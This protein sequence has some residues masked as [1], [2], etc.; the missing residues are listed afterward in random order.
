MPR[1]NGYK[2]VES[3][4]CN[5]LYPFPPSSVLS[6]NINTINT[7]LCSPFNIY[8]HVSI[9]GSKNAF[10]G[11][12]VRSCISRA[13]QTY[14]QDIWASTS[15]EAPEKTLKLICFTGKCLLRGPAPVHHT[16]DITSVQ[17]SS[18]PK[19][20]ANC[21]LIFS[22]KTSNFSGISWLCQ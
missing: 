21:S 17:H 1:S 7:I 15:W 9:I 22:F 11:V 12:L 20:L 6:R 19:R 8:I 14:F 2:A 16:D 5:M 10:A 18:Q 3:L 13:P 4:D